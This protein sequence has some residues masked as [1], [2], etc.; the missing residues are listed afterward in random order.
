MANGINVNITGETLQ[1]LNAAQ[2]LNTA[3]N[4]IIQALT[5]CYGEDRGLELW[6]E[7]S[8]YFDPIE[9]RIGRYLIMAET[10]EGCPASTERACNTECTAY[11]AGRC[12]FKS[13]SNCPRYNAIYRPRK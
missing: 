4:A 1:F 6:G 5:D 8:P 11:A 9:D 12:P 7:L 2:T 3:K 10:D 13:P